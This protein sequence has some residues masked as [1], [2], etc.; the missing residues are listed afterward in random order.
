MLLYIGLIAVES[1]VLSPLAA[2]VCAI[3]GLQPLFLPLDTTDAS[4][5]P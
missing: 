2:N 5:S 3:G 4:T 1:G